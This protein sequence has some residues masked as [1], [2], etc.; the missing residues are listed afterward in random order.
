M[1]EYL[2]TL[3]LILLPGF[4]LVAQQTPAQPTYTLKVVVEGVNN[5]AGNIGVL[6][7]NSEKGWAED[8]NAALQ[9]V[10]VP[11]T[12]G[13]VIVTV[14]NLPAGKYALAVAHDVNKNH[15][16]DRNFLG[17]PKEQWG[18]SNNPHAT[19]KTPAFS[20]ATFLV[21]A[22]QEIHIKMQ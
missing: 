22:D 20:R 16:L 13:T 18:M 1:R 8:R 10:V 11:A 4:F 12:P 7:F 19:L 15:K 5:D 14:Q 2:A 9:D 3:L 21:N 6:V 17:A